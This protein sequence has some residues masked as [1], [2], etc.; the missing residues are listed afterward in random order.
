[1]RRPVL[2]ASASV[3]LLA[4]FVVGAISV[5]A[6]IPIA[7]LQVNP[8]QAAPGGSVQ[9]FIHEINGS[10]YPP[11]TFHWDSITG[12][13]LATVQPTDDV[14]GVGATVTVPSNATPGYHQFI[15]TEPLPQQSAGE[16]PSWG[17]PVRGAIYVTAAPG[18]SAPPLTNGPAQAT[19]PAGLSTGP[20]LSIP[21]LAL[22][23]LGVAVLAAALAAGTAVASRSRRAA[24]ANASSTR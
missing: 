19:A 6:C 11:V 17:M 20:G 10:A 13:V 1:M 3:A 16:M 15:A 14:Q 8:G 9:L 5:F 23:A 7:I 18:G 2:I 12:P 21:I 22:I 4:A 24:A